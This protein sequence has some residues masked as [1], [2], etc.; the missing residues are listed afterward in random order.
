MKTKT[1][2]KEKVHVVTLGCSKNFVD[3]ENLITHL[4]HHKIAVEHNADQN[5]SEIVIIN[6]CGFID[7][8][9][10]ESIDTILSYAELKKTGRLKK[11]FVTGCLSQR[12]K[13]QLEDEIKEVDAFY[14]TMELPL[15]LKNFEIDYKSELIGERILLKPSHYAY[16]KISEGCNRTCSFC[17]I[18]LMRGAHV[19]RTIESIVHEVKHLTTQGVKEIILIA[20]ELTYYGLDI[21]KQRCLDQLV[22]EL[23]K[24]DGV[25]WIRLH[26]AYPAKFPMEIIEVMKSEPKVCKYLDIPLQ[27]AS[28]PILK[29]MKRQT[30]QAEMQALIDEIRDKI[31][32]I[33]LRTTML[34]GF[35]GE[36]EEDVQQVIEFIQRNRFDRLGVFTYSHEDGTSAY[37]LEDD[38]P[39]EIKQERASRVMDIQEQISLELNQ[40]KV[41][42]IFRVLV[43]QKMSGNYVGRTEADSPEVDNEVHI[44]AQNLYLRI[45]DFV[46]AKITAADHFDLIAIAQIKG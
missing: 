2:Q 12:Y 28:D 18:P 6:T 31:P 13:D 1:F 26:Y 30:T 45:G 4:A 11:L 43:D 20:Q 41:G 44:N 21:Y 33:S 37:E 8:A 36:T 35:P 16:V 34:L 23:C 42:K 17:A 25:E 9:K 5:D 24:I 40:E 19:S 22:R 39:L 15:L 27:H 14:G 10:E 3:S 46:E 38:I 7:K 32:G 29:A